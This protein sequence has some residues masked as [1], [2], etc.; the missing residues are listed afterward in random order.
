MVWAKININN[1]TNTLSNN[2]KSQFLLAYLVLN[3][4]DLVEESD[5]D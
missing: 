3:W 1:A 2:T 5:Q 4:N